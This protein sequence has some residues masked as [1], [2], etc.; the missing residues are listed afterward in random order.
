M[1]VIVSGSDYCHLTQNGACFTDGVGNHANNER[2]TVRATQSLYATATYF[3][4]ETY[5]DFILMSG[6]R[7]SGTAGPANVQLAAGATVLWRADR[8]VI[9]GGF[10]ICGST[11]PVAAPP[12]PVIAPSPP[13]VSYTHLTLP[14]K[15]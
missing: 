9:N 11:S 13:T 15:A 6:T 8:S 4:T 1:W 14:T 2:C 10:I 7:Y 12:P 3:Q 5:Y